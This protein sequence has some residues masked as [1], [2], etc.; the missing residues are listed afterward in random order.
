LASLRRLLA[1][2]GRAAYTVY[3]ILGITAAVFSSDYCKM[4][5]IRRT[6]R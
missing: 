6:C 4:S 5:T 3:S 2:I 1:I